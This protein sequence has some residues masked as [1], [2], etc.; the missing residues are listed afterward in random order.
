M[1]GDFV[2]L[3]AA[4]TFQKE[5]EAARTRPGDGQFE[6]NGTL[7]A[8][9]IGVAIGAILFVA[10]YV[11]HRRKQRKEGHE[12]N[13]VSKSRSQTSKPV[14]SAAE[15]AEEGDGDSERQRIRKRRRRRDHR[16]RNPTLNETGGL[17]PLRPDDELPKF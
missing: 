14:E 1:G 4:E 8:V 5:V 16:P 15:K 10:A 9:G 13:R 2:L 7:I 3:A 11:H 6:F 12:G 17:P